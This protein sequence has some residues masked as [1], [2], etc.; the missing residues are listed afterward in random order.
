MTIFP[1]LAWDGTFDSINVGTNIGVTLSN[2]TYGGVDASN[3]TRSPIKRRQPQIS[4]RRH[5]K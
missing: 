2:S 5:Y 3:Y 4:P 1:S